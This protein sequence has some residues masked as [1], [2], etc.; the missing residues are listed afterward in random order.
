MALFG[1]H[2]V[3]L[4]YCEVGFIKGSVTHA[5]FTVKDVK[6]VSNVF[7][8]CR[9][10]NIYLQLYSYIPSGVLSTII[11]FLTKIQQPKCLKRLHFMSI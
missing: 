7:H 8:Y 6:G 4:D 10:S 5:L 3:M 9:N 2:K 11:K 1:C